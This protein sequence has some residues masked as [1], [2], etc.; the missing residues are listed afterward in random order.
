MVET[1]LQ[2]CGDSSDA[3][4]GEESSFRSDV[5]LLVGDLSDLSEIDC[6]RKKI[7][8]GTAKICLSVLLWTDL[9][10]VLQ[11]QSRG[12]PVLR[13]QRFFAFIAQFMLASL[14][15]RP[16]FYAYNRHAQTVVCFVL[17]LWSVSSRRIDTKEKRLWVLMVGINTS[18]GLYLTRISCRNR[19]NV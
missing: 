6:W 18:I 10:F 7:L 3:G 1:Y 19:F 11:Y 14:R 2:Q 17:S 13:F 15:F 9:V 4:D 16:I 12:D 5:L 8:S